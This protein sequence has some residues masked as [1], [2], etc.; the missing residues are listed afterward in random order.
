MLGQVPRSGV[1]YY[2]QFVARRNWQKSGD[3][4]AKPEPFKIINVDP[5]SIRFVSERRFGYKTDKFL[6]SAR[7]VGG[8]WDCSDFAFDSKP[9]FEAFYDRYVNDQD[10]EEIEHFQNLVEKV[11]SGYRSNRYQSV[12]DVYERFE[13]YDKLYKKIAKHGYRSKEEL[14]DKSGTDP[15]SNVPSTNPQRFKYL[16]DEVLVNIGR[17]GELLFCGGHHRLSIA[18]LLKIKKIPVRVLVRHTG[19]QQYRDHLYQKPPSELEELGVSHPDL[20]DIIG[21]QSNIR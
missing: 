13:K 1:P 16:Y 14:A 3:F 4:V 20:Q 18:K 6:S 10:W 9:E 15:F 5:S 11:E 12:N 2:Y 7:I 8:D 21:Y 17:D 19:W